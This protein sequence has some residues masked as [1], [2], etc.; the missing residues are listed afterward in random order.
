MQNHTLIAQANFDENMVHDYGYDATKDNLVNDV[1]K[2]QYNLFNGSLQYTSSYKDS[3]RINHDIKGSYCN[4]SDMFNSTENNFD[5]NA[6]LSAFIQKQKVDV[7]ILAQYFGDADNRST[8]TAWNLGLNPYFATVEKHWDAHIGL[9]AYLDAVNGGTTILPD[10]IARYHVADNAVIIY[11]GIDGDRQYNSYLSLTRANPFLQDTVT[12]QYTVTPYHL[13]VGFTGN[14]TN[15]ITYDINGSESQVK[16]MPLFVTDTIETLR[17]RFTVVYDDVQVIYAHADIGY[18]MKEDVRFTLSGDWYKYTATNQLEA[19]YHPTLK[20]NLLGE[21]TFQQKYIFRADFFVVN[22]QYAPQYVTGVLTAK[23]LSGY[24]D[25]N[26]GIDYR[27]SK[28]F[29]AFIH[30]NNIANTAYYQW[31]NYPTQRFNF[32]L[33]VRLAF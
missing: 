2:E 10:L 21:Y 24:P 8:T 25:L 14:I 30:V 16:N 29:T 1:T 22:S 28:F 15:Q 23:E 26:L 3:S 13:F 32:L 33:G 17:N 11:A 9:K 5:L 7:K 27:Y 4:Y 20:I 31:D 18:R 6:H 12:H 19:W